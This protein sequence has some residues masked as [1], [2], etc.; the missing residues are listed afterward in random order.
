MLSQFRS[1]RGVSR[2]LCRT[3]ANKAPRQNQKDPELLKNWAAQVRELRR[4]FKKEYEDNIV[5]VKEMSEE[6]K[7]VIA[8]RKA[9]KKRFMDEVRRQRMEQQ[10]KLAE[11]RREER[12]E[13][14]IIKHQKLLERQARIEK[15]NMLA[16]RLAVYRQDL[17]IT[18]ENVDE[19]ITVDMFNRMVS[20]PGLA[21]VDLHVQ[22]WNPMKPYEFQEDFEYYEKIRNDVYESIDKRYDAQDKALRLSILREMEEEGDEVSEDKV[23]ETRKFLTEPREKAID[24]YA[25]RESLQVAQRLGGVEAFSRLTKTKMYQM[26]REAG[27]LTPEEDPENWNADGTVSLPETNDEYSDMLSPE[28]REASQRLKKEKMM[29]LEFQDMALGTRKVDI[30]DIDDDFETKFNIDQNSVFELGGTN[31]PGHSSNIVN[32]EEVKALAKLRWMVLYAKY[33]GE[34]GI[35]PTET[36]LPRFIEEYKEGLEAKKATGSRQGNNRSNLEDIQREQANLR[37]K[38]EF[39]ESTRGFLDEFFRISKDDYDMVSKI[40]SLPSQEES[41]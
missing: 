3:L 36:G 16:L 34:N 28:A 29:G 32:V 15:D 38:R 5:E 20:I 41:E 17:W 21:H 1:Y 24:E 31:L 14:K 35:V 39:E 40:D 10:V 33:C 19:K 30:S 13:E 2:V 11:Q 12:E 22:D 27:E 4:S 9:A 7:Q 23:E 6:E 25:R 18:K 37:E 26:L 8:Q